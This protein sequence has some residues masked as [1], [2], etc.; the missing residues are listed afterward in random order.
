MI[1][2]ESV[3]NREVLFV[4]VGEEVSCQVLLWGIWYI[5]GEHRLDCL[6]GL[7][8]GTNLASIN[9]I[10]DVHIYSRPVDGG[11]GQYLIFSIPLWLLL[12]SLSILS[13]SL[14]GIQ[15]L[16]PFNKTP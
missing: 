16:S 1:F 12:R 5:S 10:S 6:L 14:G 3:C 7:M 9:I 4:V 2:T 11:L 13:Y 15:T 8:L